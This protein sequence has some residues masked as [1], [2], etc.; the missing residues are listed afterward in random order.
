MTRTDAAGRRGAPM[1]RAGIGAPTIERLVSDRR[2]AL[3]V[4]VGV[5]A[6][7]GMITAL[8]MPRGP[9]GTGD[10]LAV[11][12]LGLAVGA[13]AGALLRTMWAVVPTGLA[14][15]VAAE[16]GRLG[17]SGPT[18][19]ALRF[20]NTFGVL[21]FL[22]GRG[23]HGLLVLL[24]MLVGA[25]LGTLWL[26]RRRGD[27]PAHGPLRRA[28]AGVATIVGIVLTAG[29]GVVVAL[30]ASTPPVIDTTGTPVPGAIASLETIRLGGVDQSVMIRA[31]DPDKPV[32]LYLAGGPGQSDLALARALST[33]WVDDVVFVDWD[34]RGT[35][36]SY[37]AIEPAPS[38]TLEQAVADT[39]QLTEVLRDRFDESKIYLMGESWGT[40]LGT[41]AVERRPDLYHAYIGSGQMVD[42]R[43]TDRRIYADLIAYAARVGDADLAARLTAMGEPPYHDTPW[44]NA[45]VMVWY[46]LLYDPYTPSA[47]YLARG[48]AAGL[49]PFGVLG[50]EYAL[51]EKANVLRGLI[52]MFSLMYPQIQGLDLRTEVARLEVPVVVLDGAAE[53]DGRRDLALE[54]F[55]R[56]EAPSKRL[57]T[58]EN[59]A[60]AVAFEQADA[61][62]RL[63]VDELIPGT[64]QP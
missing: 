8:A 48:E 33:G 59:A 24:P 45:Q 9:V 53:L 23:L 54:W 51:I 20:D 63:L 46:D 22:T 13:A 10:A 14:Y 29:L 35:G 62:E 37:G 11:M 2:A 17:A 28:L 49:D 64:Y 41:L 4:V 50:S 40:I 60:H 36:K 61:V 38:V 25:R 43:E 15:L 1:P 39:I 5:G 57:V 44:A 56:L 16:L 19:D 26:A 52:D 12:V 34:Q 55:D 42:V 47:G 3:A 6:L 58:F 18:V 30:P 31:A 7:A 27:A 32:L 21:A